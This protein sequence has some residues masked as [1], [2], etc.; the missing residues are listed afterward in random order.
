M[1]KLKCTNPAHYVKQA[2]SGFI[3]APVLVISIRKSSFN[4]VTRVRK[5]NVKRK[6][7][8]NAIYRCYTIDNLNKVDNVL[9]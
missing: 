4:S 5:K 2:R 8:V 6:N 7:S 9:W 3:F 1:Y